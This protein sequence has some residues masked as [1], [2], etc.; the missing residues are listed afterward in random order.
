M[1]TEEAIY[2]LYRLSWDWEDEGLNTKLNQ[3]DINA[4]GIV[5]SELEIAKKEFQEYRKLQQEKEELIKHC[6]N[7]IYNQKESIELLSNKKYADIHIGAITAYKNVLLKLKE[8][9]NE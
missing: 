1:N 7:E 6:E 8:S 4:I 5:C 9:N 3:T 2:Q